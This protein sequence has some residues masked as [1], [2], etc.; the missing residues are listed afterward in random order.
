M[1]QK[2][3][4]KISNCLIL[5]VVIVFI[6]TWTSI[7]KLLQLRSKFKK[8]QVYWHMPAPN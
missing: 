5:G 1:A 4:R 8:R 2:L 7:T 6:K 3:E